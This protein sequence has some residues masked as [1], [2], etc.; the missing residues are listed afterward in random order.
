MIE[1]SRRRFGTHSTTAILKWCVPGHAK[2]INVGKIQ[3][4]Q[5]YAGEIWID[6]G[7][8][9][10]QAADKLGLREIAAAYEAR[11]EET[12]KEWHKGGSKGYEIQTVCHTAAWLEAIDNFIQTATAKLKGV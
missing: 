8:I 5:K 6:H 7:T 10:G 3:V 2:K 1:V 12:F 11:M 9:P 4:R